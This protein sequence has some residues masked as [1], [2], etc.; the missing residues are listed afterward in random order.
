LFLLGLGWGFQRRWIKM[1]THHLLSSQPCTWMPVTLFAQMPP[2][3]P[4]RT[5]LVFH[6]YFTEV[7]K[8]RRGMHSKIQ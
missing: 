6:L 3:E 5:S 2:V 1:N 7:A 4:I 8:E